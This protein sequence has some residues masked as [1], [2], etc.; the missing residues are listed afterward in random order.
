MSKYKEAITPKKM[1]R[2][3]EKAVEFGVPSRVLMENAGSAVQRVI[4][5]EIGEEINVLIVSG[6]GN[7]GGDGFVAAK[8]LA[9]HGANVN[10]FLVGEPEEIGSE[11]SQSNWNIIKKMEQNI[12]VYPVKNKSNLEDIRNKLDKSDVIIDAMLGTGLKDHLRE[13]FTSVVK[14][15]N[16][17]NIPIVSVDVPTGID[18]LSGEV[19]G[20]AIEASYTVTFHR[21]KEGLLKSRSHTGELMVKDIGIPKQVE[22]GVL[23]K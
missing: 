7:N 18:A 13:P 10:V 15:L 22:D 4:N 14:I 21:A 12:N 20:E 23:Q 2:I 8:H 1:A 3:D 6:T 9:N 19:H 16:N 11:E 5:D 17:S